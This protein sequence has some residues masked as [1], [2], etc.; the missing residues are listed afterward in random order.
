MKPAARARRARHVLRH[1]R[2]LA[3]NVA[4]VMARERARIDVVAAAG[5]RS[6]QE[7]DA[8]AG[9]VIAGRGGAC[10]RGERDQGGEDACRCKAHSNLRP[11][12]RVVRRLGHPCAADNSSLASAARCVAEIGMRVISRLLPSAD[13]RAAISVRSLSPLATELGFTRVRSLLSGRSRIYPTSAERVGVS[14]DPLRTRSAESPP[15]PLAA[16]H[17]RCFASAF[18]AL[19][20]AAEGRLCSPRTRG[21]VELAARA[22]TKL[23]PLLLN[24]H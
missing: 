5:R 20:T 21:E 10:E 16:L 12:S 8:L 7:I 4:P 23:F 1:D 3:G 14:G 2:G 6:D 15:H 18:L 24:L 13:S 22:R 11:R 19:R 9:V 17:S